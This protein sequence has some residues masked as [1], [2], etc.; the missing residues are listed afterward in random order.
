MAFDDWKIVMQWV[1]SV[2]AREVFKSFGTWRQVHIFFHILIKFV[3]SNQ[4]F[5]GILF[6]I[7][8]SIGL[9]GAAFLCWISDRCFIW[10]NTKMLIIILMML[11]YLSSRFFC[12][13]WAGLGFP[14]LHGAWCLIFKIMITNIMIAFFQ[15][16][17]SPQN[18]P[19]SG[20]FWFS[21]PLTRLL[22]CL[23]TSTWSS[24]DH[25]LFQI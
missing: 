7:N 19:N 2:A 24:T 20:M 13:F 1:C 23:P 14:Y 4:Y 18:V 16:T 15:S 8:R 3:V 11:I 25:G 10:M 12:E 5:A 6:H 9:W 17:L 22:S 21:W